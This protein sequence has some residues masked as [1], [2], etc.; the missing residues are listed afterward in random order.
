[1]ERHDRELSRQ[2]F[3]LLIDPPFCHLKDLG[4]TNGTRVNGLRAEKV[5]L[6]DGDVISAGKTTFLLRIDET[7]AEAREVRCR[8]CGAAAPANGAPGPGRGAGRVVLR[9]VPGAAG[10]PAE[11]PPGL[12][13]R[14]PHRRRGDGGWSSWPAARPTGASSPSRR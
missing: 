1:M 11:A 7:T 12:L 2:H 8:S 9:P 6:G 4:S 5:R 10:V 3:L 14:A 13:D